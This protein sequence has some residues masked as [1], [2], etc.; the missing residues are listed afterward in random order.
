MTVVD[1]R[2][3]SLASGEVSEEIETGTL[4]AEHLGDELAQAALVRALT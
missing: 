4:R 3:Y 1:A 2:A